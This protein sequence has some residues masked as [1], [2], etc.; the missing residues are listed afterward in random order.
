MCFCVKLLIIIFNDFTFILMKGVDMPT[1]TQADRSKSDNKKR[2]VDTAVHG[3]ARAAAS[4]IGAPI[5][6]VKA[7]QQGSGATIS[8]AFKTVTKDGYGR[9]W[10]G[11]PSYALRKG[12]VGAAGGGVMEEAKR[13]LKDRSVPEQVAGKV[14]SATGAE[15]VMSIPLEQIYMNRIN[16]GT[17]G[18]RPV[19]QSVRDYMTQAGRMATPSFARNSVG[20]AGVVGTAH[21]AN[22]YNLSREQ[23][24]AAGLVSGASTAL[25]SSPLDKA[26]QNSASL[27]REKIKEM[28][29]SNKKLPLVKR[30]IPAGTAA[31][32]VAIAPF[33]AASAVATS[34]LAERDRAEKQQ[35]SFR[36]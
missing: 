34:V 6:R 27:T 17:R 14:L 26:V 15:T 30:M 36:R 9:L 18:Y 24:A 11:L 32:G 10:S 35:S 20:W 2:A 22:R 12:V 25:I 3:G 16:P 8:K 21:A 4:I 13:R 33:A 28:R 31:R 29:K 5:D 1:K 23:T 7:T 19:P